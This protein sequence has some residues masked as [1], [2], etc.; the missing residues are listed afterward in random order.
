MIL[1]AVTN[2]QNWMVCVECYV[3]Q[4][5]FLLRNNLL[6]T[7]RVIFIHIQVKNMN[8]AIHRD[9]SKNCAWVRSPCYIPNL[10]IQIKHEK[11]FAESQINIMQETARPSHKSYNLIIYIILWFNT[12]SPLWSQILIIH[13]AE[14]VKNTDGTYGFQAIL[15]IGVLWASYVWRNFELYS[16]VHL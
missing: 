12:Y 4:S 13:S 11:S 15:Y 7:D 16:V 10:R 1:P 6:C 3:V 8:L 9:S 5:C 2:N 14:Q